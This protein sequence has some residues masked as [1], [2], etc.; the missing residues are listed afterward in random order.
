M[1]LMWSFQPFRECVKFHS[2]LRC[3]GCNAHSGWGW[4]DRKLLVGGA[5][6]INNDGALESAS[7]VSMAC[8]TNHIT[9]S[10]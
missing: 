9:F 8:L 10:R 3:Q 7:T 4:L 1:L 2:L 5:R 6:E